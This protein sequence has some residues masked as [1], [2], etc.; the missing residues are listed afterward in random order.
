M[1]EDT[2]PEE[3]VSWARA[4]QSCGKGQRAGWGGE[5]HAWAQSVSSQQ[6]PRTTA[7]SEPWGPGLPG[8]GTEANAVRSSSPQPAR[9][10]DSCGGAA[11][12]LP[13]GPFLMRP[14]RCVQAQPACSRAF[15]GGSPR[16]SAGPERPRGPGSELRSSRLWPR[17]CAPAACVDPNPA[18]TAGEAGPLAFSATPHVLPSGDHAL[19][20]GVLTA[21]WA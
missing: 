11:P 21:A 2:S 1:P 4:A 7:G 20:T 17:L 8:R 13:G 5:P 19:G 6:P 16:G 15:P 12:A 10:A 9:L 14:E 18:G 3:K